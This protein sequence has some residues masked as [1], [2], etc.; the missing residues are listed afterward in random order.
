[1]L[2]LCGAG[3]A[4]NGSVVFAQGRQK[5]RIGLPTRVYWP[6]IPVHV[7]QDLKL[8]EKE[9]LDAEITIYNSGGAAMEAVAAGA[10]D[11]ISASPASVAAARVRGVKAMI[12]ASGMQTPTGFYVLVKEGSAIRTLKDLEGKRLG[13]T[14]TGSTTDFLALWVMEKSGA[15][16]TRVA[17]GGGALVPNLLNGQLDAIVAFPPLGYSLLVSKEARILLDYGKEMEPSM[18]DTWVAAEDAI[19]KRPQV[20]EATLRAIFGALKHLQTNRDYGVRFVQ[21]YTQ[22]PSAVAVMEYER[23]LLPLAA[24]G[25]LKR[26][27]VENSM[28]LARLAGATSLP[29]VNDIFTERFAPL[30]RVTSAQ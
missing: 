30:K 13:I 5:V 12:V 29:P 16:I 6:A 28:R 10:C 22:L 20:V 8:Y 9:G 2:W 18:P 17:V 11:I 15:K 14:A 23:T 4:L 24:D 7:A 21:N 25:A 1:M 26:D 19:N 3:L 27:W